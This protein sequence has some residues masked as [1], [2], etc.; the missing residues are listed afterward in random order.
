MRAA[1]S[2]TEKIDLNTSL[3]HVVFVIMKARGTR[4]G[5]ACFFRSPNTSDAQLFLKSGR[6]R[7][8]I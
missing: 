2:L 7:R 1:K 4:I 8:L 5:R 3:G 6:S